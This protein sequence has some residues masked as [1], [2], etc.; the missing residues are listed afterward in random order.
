MKLKF[1]ASTREMVK[2]INKRD[3]QIVADFIPDEVY[4]HLTLEFVP[5]FNGATSDERRLSEDPTA[6]ATIKY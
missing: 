5:D 2:E 6:P 4:D 1:P 3:I